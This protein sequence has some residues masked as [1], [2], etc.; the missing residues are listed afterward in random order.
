MLRVARFLFVH[1]WLL[2][3][4]L[5]LVAEIPE[6]AGKL[7]ARRLVHL[8][9]IRSIEPALIIRVLLSVQHVFEQDRIHL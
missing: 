4:R 1:S 3:M 8:F 2:A 5:E 9:L 6:I 7:C